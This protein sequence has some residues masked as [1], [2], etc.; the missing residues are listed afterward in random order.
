MRHLWHGLKDHDYEALPDLRAATDRIDGRHAGLHFLALD[1]T[2]VIMPT[3]LLL[4]LQ[5]R[6]AGEIRGR[7]MSAHQVTVMKVCSDGR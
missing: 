1:G 4:H 3:K 6:I 2:A 5:Q 7:S